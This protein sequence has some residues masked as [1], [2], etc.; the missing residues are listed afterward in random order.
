MADALPPD[1]DD[2]LAWVAYVHGDAELFQ[3][4]YA[5][6]NVYIPESVPLN[7]HLCKC[8]GLEVASRLCSEIGGSAYNVPIQKV[9]INARRILVLILSWAGMTIN[10]I[11]EAS[12]ITARQ[13]SNIRADLRG[14]GF[15]PPARRAGDSFNNERF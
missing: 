9:R 4:S 3:R 8:L 13:V 2:I 14:D 10:A 15:L 11:A 12:E 6:Q 1:D 7:H 5:G